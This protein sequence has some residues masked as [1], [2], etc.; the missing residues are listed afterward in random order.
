MRERHDNTWCDVLWRVGSPAELQLALSRGR[1]LEVD[2]A[3]SVV[4][5]VL[6]RADLRLGATYVFRE[7]DTTD[8]AG[9][10]SNIASGH[11]RESTAAVASDA[12][13]RAAFG[14][15]RLFNDGESYTFRTAASAVLQVDGLVLPDPKRGAVL[16]NEAKLAPRAA[17]VDDVNRLLIL[18]GILR[19]AR[20]VTNFPSELRPYWSAHVVPFLSGVSFEPRVLAHTVAEGVVPVVRGGARFHV[21]P[22]APD[23]QAVL[24]HMESRG[25][26]AA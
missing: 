14:P 6:S 21:A 18:E 22:Q 16:M 19:G 2:A 12:R 9:A 1:L 23:P 25:A 24:R 20:A 3:G 13:V 26:A 7:A 17:D 15:L 11:E 4:R 5:N 8:I 10:V